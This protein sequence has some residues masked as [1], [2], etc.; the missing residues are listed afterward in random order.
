MAEIN[1][2]G[3]EVPPNVTIYI[4]NLNEKIKLE[5]KHYSTMSITHALCINESFWIYG[6]WDFFFLIRVEEVS[7]RGV[8]AIWEDIGCAGL[9]DSEA[10][11]P[12]L[13]CVRWS[14]LCHQCA[15]PNAGLPILRQAHGIFLWKNLKFSFMDFW[16]LCNL[17][18]SLCLN[19]HISGVG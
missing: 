13:G 18:P 16:G 5:G 11:R 10:Q 7:A 14:F 6:N 17:I 8:L 4:N 12:S 2:T 1:T 15:S 9:Q 19:Y 3:T